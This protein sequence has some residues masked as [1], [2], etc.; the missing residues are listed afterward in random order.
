MRELFLLFAVVALA[1]VLTTLPARTVVPIITVTRCK[2]LA[3]ESSLV[4]VG[5]CLDT[6]DAAGP[7]I[8]K[9]L[10]A[11]KEHLVPVVTRF[12]VEAVLKGEYL[13]DEIEVRHHRWRDRYVPMS[14]IILIEFKSWI[15]E[16]AKASEPAVSCEYLLFLKPGAERGYG[17]ATGP[18]RARYS[19]RELKVP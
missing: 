5:R 7:I 3:R 9:E 18:K 10:E 1:F 13:R 11:F 15:I 4:V 16:G 19:V 8:D 6:K 14:K 17:L 2:T 12:S